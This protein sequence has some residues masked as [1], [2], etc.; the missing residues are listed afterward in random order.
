M[1]FNFNWLCGYYKNT[2]DNQRRVTLN[3][4]SKVMYMD[5]HLLIRLNNLV[6]I[7]IQKQVNWYD[8]E[9][10]QSQTADLSMAPRG[11]DTEH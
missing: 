7:I 5:S 9:L 11:S 6:S 10:P 4:S 1:L 8:Q 2:D 3:E